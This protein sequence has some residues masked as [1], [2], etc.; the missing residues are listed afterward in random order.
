ME[1]H[2]LHILAFT[3]FASQ[4]GIALITINHFTLLHQLGHPTSIDLSIEFLFAI[5]NIYTTLT[6]NLV[7]PSP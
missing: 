1:E 6:R 7:V 2:A 4:E 3:S 5:A